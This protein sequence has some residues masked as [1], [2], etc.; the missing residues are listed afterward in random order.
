MTGSLACGLLVTE[1]AV[2]VQRQFN[3]VR[4][5]LIG[6]IKLCCLPWVCTLPQYF[7]Q[8]V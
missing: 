3:V 2:N 5:R 4:E 1:V 8:V 6:S 7:L